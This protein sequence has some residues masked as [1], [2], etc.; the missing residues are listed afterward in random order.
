MNTNQI[1]DDVR[2]KIEA[3][4]QS[5]FEKWAYEGLELPQIEGLKDDNYS[6]KESYQSV[7]Q[8]N[9]EIQSDCYKLEAEISRLKSELQSAQE[10]IEKLKSN[11]WISV[12]DR[13]PNPGQNV[14]VYLKGYF[15]PFDVAE[16]SKVFAMEFIANA[17]CITDHVTHW[18]P[19]PASPE[20][21]IIQVNSVYDSPGCPFDEILF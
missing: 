4:S 3:K 2:E 11:K 6:L 5:E 12:S 19:L 1:P 17:I 13:L 18:Q 20:T 9:D 10:E 8:A 14:L 21:K 15:H 16:Y 7:L